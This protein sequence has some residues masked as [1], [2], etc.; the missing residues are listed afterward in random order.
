MPSFTNNELLV[1]AQE[2]ARD[3]LEF[4]IY[5]LALSLDV[6]IAELSSDYQIPVSESDHDYNSYVALKRM[7]TSLDRLQ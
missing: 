6:D 5:K 2:R 1:K 4:N 7:C 3:Y